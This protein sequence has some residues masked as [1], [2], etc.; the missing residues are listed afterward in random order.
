M[1]NIVAS[2]GLCCRPWEEQLCF[3]KALQHVRKP[4]A[5]IWEL[6]EIMSLC[7]AHGGCASHAT[8]L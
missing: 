6:L 8:A 3:G 4:V 7:R 2:G 5:D 1:P